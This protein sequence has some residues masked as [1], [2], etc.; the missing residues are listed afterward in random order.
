[1]SG[2]E[3]QRRLLAEGFR[4]PIIFIS[5]HADERAQMPALDER[6]VTFIRKPFS[7][8]A[9][10]SAVESALGVSRGL[11]PPVR[12]D[13]AAHSH[14]PKS[15]MHEPMRVV[16]GILSPEYGPTPAGRYYHPSF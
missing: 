4:I 7:E 14:H 15:N 1:M 8:E 11:W 2:F 12:S 6:A 5:A 13:G 9:L 16:I 3:L 10:L